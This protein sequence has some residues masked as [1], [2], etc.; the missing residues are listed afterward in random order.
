MLAIDFRRQRLALRRKL[1]LSV[2]GSLPEREGGALGP[3]EGLLCNL[4]EAFNKIGKRGVAQKFQAWLL[5]FFA[6]L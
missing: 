6:Y 2:T 1:R 4:P 5:P 3:R